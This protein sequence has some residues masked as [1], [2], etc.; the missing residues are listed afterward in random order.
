MSSLHVQPANEEEFGFW[1]NSRSPGFRLVTL[2][3]GFVTFNQGFLA[4]KIE[5]G[6][7]RLKKSCED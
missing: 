6:K 7:V 2:L 4:Y 3:R 1:W 5:D